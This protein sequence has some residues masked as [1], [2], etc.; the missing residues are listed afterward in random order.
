V[1]TP[2]TGNERE[3]EPGTE[4]KKGVSDTSL[5]KSKPY[6]YTEIIPKRYIHYVVVDFLRGLKRN[7]FFFVALQSFRTLTASHIG[8]F[9]NYLDIC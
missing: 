3:K 5:T 9:L 7:C 6:R 2:T 1:E 4:R 8:G